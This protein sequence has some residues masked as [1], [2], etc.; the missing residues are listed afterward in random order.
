M[1]SAAI[2]CYAAYVV[3]ERAAAA[4]VPVLLGFFLAMLFEPY[5]SLWRRLVHNATLAL[6]LMLATVLIPAGLVIWYGGASIVQQITHLVSTAPMVIVR[7]SNW[8]NATFPNAQTVCAQ[9][10]APSELMAFFTAPDLFAQ[11]I[12]ATL[13]G[14]YGAT[15]AKAG[16]GALR[17]LSAVTTF[18]IPMLFFAYFVTVGRK[19]SGAACVKE[20]PFLKDATKHF[21]AAQIDSFCDILVGFFRRQVVICL[22][23]GCLYGAGFMLVGFPYGFV[24]GFLLGVLN[25]AP[26]LGSVIIMP[27]ALPLAYFGDG[28]GMGALCATLGVWIAGQLLDGYLIT[29]K[30]QGDKTGLGYAGVIFSF[31]FWSVIFHSFIGLLLAIPLSAFCVV[32]WRALKEKIKGVI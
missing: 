26:F 18:L 4:L 11:D 16:L 14:Q 20:M 29:P 31:F 9:F 1:A 24:L 23:E 5:F 27:L 8:A 15:M 6:I 30:I 22:I 28:G 12:L 21:V 3:F 10:G 13:T 25:L 32:F 2:V 19:V 7:F 17:Y